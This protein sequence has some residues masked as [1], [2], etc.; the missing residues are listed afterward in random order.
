MGLPPFKDDL[1]P[2]EATVSIVGI[3]NYT[4]TKDFHFTIN[5]GDLS[6]AVVDPIPDQRYTDGQIKPKLGRVRLKDR[7]EHVSDELLLYESQDFTVTYGENREVGE[8][9]G[10]VTLTGM[11]DYVDSNTSATVKFNI[12]T[13]DLDDATI[14]DVPDQVYTGSAITPALDVSL[15]GDEL[16]EGTH[17]RVTWKNN[18]NVGEATGTVRGIEPYCAGTRTVKFK[19]TPKPVTVT[20]NNLGKT[21]G[22]PEPKLTATVEGTVGSDTVA[23]SLS[24]KTDQ[25]AGKYAITASGEA[26][27]GNYSVTFKGGTFT[28]EPASVTDAEVAHVDDV[29]F[30]GAAFE[31]DPEV[32]WKGKTL[33]R[34][35][36]YTLLYVGNQHAGQATVT[37]KGIGNFK[38]EQGVHFEIAPLDL[39]SDG[40][41]VFVPFQVH[42]GSALEP[43]PRRVTAPGRDGALLV[44]VEDVDYEI[45]DGAWTDNVDV[46]TGHVVVNGIGDFCGSRTGDFNIVNDGDLSQGSMDDI[47]DQVYTGGHIEPVLHVYLKGVDALLRRDVD[48]TARFQNNENVGTARVFVEGI[49]PLSGSQQAT[50]EIK[51]ADIGEALVAA[52]DATYDGT[53]QEPEPTV[54]WNEMP[55]IE[56]TAYEVIKYE[57]NVHAGTATVTVKGRGNFEGE[58]S[59]EFEI[60]QRPLTV[61]ADSAERAYTGGPLVAGGFTSEGLA[62]GDAVVSAAVAGSQTDVGSSPSTVSDAKVENAAGEDVTSDYD[63]SYEDGTLSVTTASIADAVAAVPDQ[64]FTGGPLE[65]SPTVTWNEMLLIEG[66][67]YEVTGYAGNVHAG[68]ARVTVRGKGDFEGTATGEFEILPADVSAATVVAPTQTYDGTELE[69]EPTVTW[70]EMLLIE[71]T[72]YEV[73]GYAGNVHAGTAEVAVRGKGD[74]EGAATGEFEI[75]QRQL[76]VTADS[77]ERGYDGAALTADGFASEGLAEGDAVVSANVSGSQTDAGSSANTASDAKVENAAGEDVTADYDISYADGTL[78]IEPANLGDAGRFSI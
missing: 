23:Y 42:T 48:Y 56:G 52:A 20:A 63:I 18:L 11:G 60:S 67:D 53:A 62:E 26:S 27:Q 14:E 15:G 10:S 54:T 70:N 64:T 33:E 72:D 65:P 51:P 78:T 68:T 4:G 59:G 21:F 17:Y 3:G 24:R 41:E 55:L 40:C 69:P 74:F 22:D 44:L 49:A 32:T 77:A 12:I 57:G 16:V 5:K 75:S 28:I 34:D 6:T 13:A 37:V 58:A 38:E 9:K 66:T 61:T 2:G 30:D 73:T 29:T 76:T 36:D 31:P 43:H 25:D 46:G 45:R 35:K 7:N 47:P 1:A 39:S 50:F 71:G 19:V 8:N